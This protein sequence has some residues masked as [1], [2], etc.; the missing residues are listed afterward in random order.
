[1]WPFRR[2]VRSHRGKVGTA[3][4]EEIAERGA[5]LKIKTGFGYALATYRK[6]DEVDSAAYK[7]VQEIGNRLKIDRVYAAEGLI[8]RIAAHAR[9]NMS[10]VSGVLCHGTRNGAELRWFAGHFPGAEILGTEISD[11]AEQFPNTVQWDF[12]DFREDWR[13]RWSLIYS[14]SWDHS[15]DP[16][17][18]FQAWSDSLAPG[19]RLYVEHNSDSLKVDELDLFAA[20]AKALTKFVV[21]GSGGALRPAG[22]IDGSDFGSSRSVLVFEK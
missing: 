20:T 21:K 22:S 1:M 3:I 7:A 18:M 10:N 19:G 15:H 14:N 13:D 2:R 12:H 16:L 8:E 11:T 6:G 4:A 17:R 5:H 9:A